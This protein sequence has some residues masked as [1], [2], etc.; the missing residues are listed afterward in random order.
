M[1]FDAKRGLVSG[2]VAFLTGGLSVLAKGVFDRYLAK[3]NY[4][5]AM[6]EAIDSGEIP[7]WDGGAD[8]TE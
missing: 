6:I 4:C 3:E 7:V 2:S 5:E 1:T 8:G